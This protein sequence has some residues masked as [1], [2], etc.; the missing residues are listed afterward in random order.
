MM[1]G[2]VGGFKHHNGYPHYDQCLMS[3]LMDDLAT[4][5]G[6]NGSKQN[7]QQLL[8]HSRVQVAHIPTERAHRMTQQS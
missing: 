5:A 4:L 8:G 7:H 3:H 6:S 2:T 1:G